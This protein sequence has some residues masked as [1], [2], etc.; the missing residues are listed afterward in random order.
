MVL[1]HFNFKERVDSIKFAP[2]GRSDN[3]S[4]L[5][6]PIDLSLASP[7]WLSISASPSLA[8]SPRCFAVTHGKHMQVWR[9]PTMEVDFAPFVLHRTYA[10][11]DD[12][13]VSIEWSADSS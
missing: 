6:S 9:T 1:H 13:I 2:N 3:E 7:M 12:D 11:H 10:G 4:R 8:P 5:L